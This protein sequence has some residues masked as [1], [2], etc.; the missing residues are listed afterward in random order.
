MWLQ[1]EILHSCIGHV[2]RMMVL[3][4]GLRPKT[5]ECTLIMDDSCRS[6]EVEATRRGRHCHGFVPSPQAYCSVMQ[7][8]E[9][10]GLAGLFCQTKK[11]AHNTKRIGG[12]WSQI[13]LSLILRSMRREGALC[14]VLALVWRRT[15]KRKQ[16][17]TIL[18][19]I[20][21]KTQWVIAPV[22]SMASVKDST[23]RAN[24][25]F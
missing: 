6:K 3:S 11:Y 1:I 5:V 10:R 2:R 16:P 22:L 13:Q 23:A 20:I 19:V 24:L 21:E 14:Q 8:K 18:T 9:V 15:G 4:I 12:D 7:N 17:Y 25:S